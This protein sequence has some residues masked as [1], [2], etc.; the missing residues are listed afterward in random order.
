MFADSR[1]NVWP[2]PKVCFELYVFPCAG[3]TASSACAQFF[4]FVHFFLVVFSSSCSF[5]FGSQ[6][7]S[8]GEPLSEAARDICT[9]FSCSVTLACSFGGSCWLPGMRDSRL[10][11]SPAA[12]RA[13]IDASY[14][15]TALSS[16]ADAVRRILT[17]R[18]SLSSDELF[19][20]G[21]SLNPPRTETFLLVLLRS[22]ILR[23]S[24]TRF[25]IPL[26]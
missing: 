2:L 20:N 4:L 10:T 9:P 11:A 6:K 7:S 15:L 13:A 3:G 24:A 22:R 25:S 26:F 5:D 12:Y 8:F 23:V 17:Q 18:Y 14:A 16:F 1:T 21:R 19:R